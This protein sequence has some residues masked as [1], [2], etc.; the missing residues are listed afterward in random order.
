MIKLICLIWQEGV[1]TVL[2][3][4]LGKSFDLITAVAAVEG[5]LRTFVT[6]LIKFNETYKYGVHGENP[7]QSQTRA[8]LFDV[9]F[10]MLCSIVNIYGSQ[11]CIYQVLLNFCFEIFII[12]S[13]RVAYS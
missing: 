7:K 13:I 2:C 5:K 4:I 12:T 6:K 10:L 3:P 11:V 9:S 1:Q 8:L